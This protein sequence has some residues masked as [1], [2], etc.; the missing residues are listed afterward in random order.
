MSL[1]RTTAL[2]REC[3][4]VVGFCRQLSDEEWRTP[5]AAPGWRIQDV[6][7]HLAANCHAIFTPASIALMTSKDIERTNDVYVDKRRD[8]EP[9]K[10]LGELETWGKRL[11]AMSGILARTPIARI[12]MPLGELG[13]FPAAVL[14][15]SAFVFDQHTHLRHDIAP[16]L[17]RPAPDSDELRMAV[18]LEWMFAVLSNQLRTARPDWLDRPISI[19]LSG[20]GGGHWL[21]APDG[22]IAPGAAEGAA[23]IVG[24]GLDFPG[25]ATARTP[26]RESDVKITGDAELGGR[27]LDSMNVV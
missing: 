6:V 18:V 25:W 13:R 19:N 2:R 21:V 24:V 8:W 12:P 16:A 23:Q 9:L 1:D 7:A 22:S 10:V 3:A 26:W 20:P 4:E 11:A 15:N 27:L 5:S 17:G 14:L